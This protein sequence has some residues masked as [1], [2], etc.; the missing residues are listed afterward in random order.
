MRLT[1]A[2]VGRLKEGAERTLV[3]RYAKRLS[4]AHSTGLGPLQETEIPESRAGS[5]AER[6]TDEAA[7]LLK[8]AGDADVVVVLDE[9]GKGLSSAELAQLIGRWR[10]E[11]RR[12]ASFLIGGPDGHGDGARQAAHLMLSLSPMTLPHG[13]A[14]AVM[15]EQLYRA[16]TILAGHPYHRT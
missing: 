5:T 10:D 11:G 9:R 7:R 14:R 4:S 15:A 12:H 2:A 6:K 16:T 3:A 1:I 8:A 13:L